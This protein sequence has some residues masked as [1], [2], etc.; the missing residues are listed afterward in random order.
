M[1]P[2]N[3]RLTEWLDPVPVAQ[4]FCEGCGRY[5]FMHPG[6]PDVQRLRKGKPFEEIAA[7]TRTLNV[8]VTEVGDHTL[9]EQFEKGKGD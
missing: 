4:L 7:N 9:R 5:A 1:L 3:D 8:Q 6:H 2:G